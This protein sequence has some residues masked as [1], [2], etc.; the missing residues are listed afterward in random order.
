MHHFSIFSRIVGIRHDWIMANA[1]ERQICI[2]D[3]LDKIGQFVYIN[4]TMGRREEIIQE[5]KKLLLKFGFRKTTMEDI[6]KA[7]RIAKATLYHYFTSKEDIFREI[8]HREGNTLRKK[9]QEAVARGRTPREKLEN[10]A[11]T[12]LHFLRELVPYYK[13]LTEKYYSHI[14]FVE[15]ERKDFD[16]FELNTLEVIL[17]EGVEKGEFEIPD[18]RLY[19]FLILQVMKGLEY[20]LATGKA[21]N[22][23]GKELKLDDALQYLLDI[24]V[25]G[26][27]K[28]ELR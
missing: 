19:A 23:D 26:I 16:S 5:A 11:R 20:P 7:A 3:Q 14:P 6:A 28:K 8:I 12:R 25:R 1:G 2:V 13:L 10:Y 24:L 21:L 15:K 27:G 18:P 17:R 4:R 9:L 22:L